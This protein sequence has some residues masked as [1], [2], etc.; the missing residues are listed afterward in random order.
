MSLHG[1]RFTSP[2]LLS[3]LSS[4][5]EQPI[6]WNS[7]ASHFKAFHYKHKDYKYTFNKI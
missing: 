7:P 1:Q 6:L 4:A 3:E 2:L 5:T